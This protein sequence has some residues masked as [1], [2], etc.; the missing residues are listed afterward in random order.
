MLC[1]STILDSGSSI[2]IFNDRT[3]FRDLRPAPANTSVLTGGGNC[4]IEGYGTVDVTVKT[5]GDQDSTIELRD[6]AYCPSFQCN[7]ASRRRFARNRV[8][9]NQERMIME[10]KGIILAKI[11]DLYN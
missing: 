6:T 5:D 11:Y 9:F 3:R 1:N 7:I 8:F 10:W 4:L 2:H